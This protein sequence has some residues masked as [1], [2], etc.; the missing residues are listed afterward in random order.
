VESARFLRA[1]V[2]G[3]PDSDE[4]EFGRFYPGGIV[5]ISPRLPLRATV[6][7]AA[8]AEP[9]SERLCKVSDRFGSL[10]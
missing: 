10:R 2:F 8:K 3:D 6:G 1:P 5:S 9:T 7:R 4:R